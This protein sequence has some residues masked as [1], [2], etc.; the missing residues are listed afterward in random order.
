MSCLGPAL[1]GSA[2]GRLD[3][4]RWVTEVLKPE[5]GFLGTS[6]FDSGEAF[7]GDLFGDGDA[8]VQA[9]A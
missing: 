2:T 5:C 1:S 7:L 9:H 3:G 8:G 4:A 6:L